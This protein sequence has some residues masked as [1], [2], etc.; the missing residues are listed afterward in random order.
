MK[1]SRGKISVANL[2]PP[3]NGAKIC[4][5]ARLGIYVTEKGSNRKAKLLLME[6]D[7]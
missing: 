3:T 5:S 2:I 7:L 6:Q 4:N 1:L